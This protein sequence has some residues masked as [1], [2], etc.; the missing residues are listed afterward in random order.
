MQCEPLGVSPRTRPRL[1][2]ASARLGIG[3]RAKIEN[4]RFGIR[5]YALKSLAPAT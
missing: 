1:M 3:G 5:L 2:F 4:D